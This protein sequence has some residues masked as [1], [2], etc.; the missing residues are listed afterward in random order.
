MI[1]SP[2]QEAE[3]IRGKTLTPES[4]KPVHYP[5]PSN[6]PILEKSMDPLFH[7][8]VGTPA[9]FQSFSQQNQ[10]PSAQ[11]STSFY[12]EQQNA[13]NYHGAPASASVGTGAGDYTQPAG[14][15]N[16][17]GQNTQDTSIQSF[18]LQNQALAAP[19]S[20]AKSAHGQDNRSPY[21]MPY[22]ANAYHPA[23]SQA[24]PS[25][26]GQYQPSSNNEGSGV[27]FQAILDTL[28]NPANERNATPSMPTQPS[29]IHTV[30]SLSSLPAPSNLPPRPPM[31]D[32][33]SIHP[34]YNPDDDIRSYH[35]H[36]Q[37]Q[38][39]SQYRGSA[40]LQPLNV[41][42]TPTDNS[43]PP[44][45]TR[46]NQTPSTPGYRQRD[47]VDLHADD[48]EDARWPPEINRLY[49][50]FLEDERKFVTDGQWDQFP[51]GSRL[52]IG[53]L[54]VLH[55]HEKPGYQQ[56]TGNLPTEKV[57]KRDIFH[58]FYRHGKLAQ[59]SIKQA[60]GFVQFLDARSCHEALQQEQGSQ[61]R[62]RKMRTFSIVYSLSDPTNQCRP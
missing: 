52:F 19:Y 16:G 20:E 17:Y 7:E 58:R 54:G 36:S 35:P 3:H 49:E 60:Y 24:Q 9:S 34:N 33:P 10:T 8:T 13:P 55:S 32:K 5:S 31:Q 40:Q 23:P 48:D 11:S 22:A 29:Q 61:V 12:P 44:S 53:K 39:N 37:K 4:P 25:Q 2:P 57:T 50:E 51:V 56:L 14:Y 62:G 43:Y 45:A 47:S 26:G 21:P 27:N 15:S 30:S 41:P 42:N 18:S 38:P 46:H 28:N 59:I 6:I 1:S